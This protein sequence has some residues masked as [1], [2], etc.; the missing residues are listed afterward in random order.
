MI[1]YETRYADGIVPNA[2]AAEPPQV[3]V[4]VPVYRCNGC[5]QRFDPEDLFKVDADIYC[6]GCIKEMFTYRELLEDLYGTVR[7]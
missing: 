4:K 1:E 6:E 5:G 7:E 2:P 3:R